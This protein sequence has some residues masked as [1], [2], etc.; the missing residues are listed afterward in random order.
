MDPARDR[1]DTPVKDVLKPSDWDTIPIEYEF[2]GGY[3]LTPGIPYEWW[4]TYNGHNATH[5][6]TID[7]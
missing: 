1:M 6:H 3:R 7:K 4:E 2:I 5:I